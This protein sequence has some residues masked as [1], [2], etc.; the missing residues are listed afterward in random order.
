ML[1]EIISLCFA[2]YFFNGCSKIK[3]SSSLINENKSEPSYRDHNYSY[4]GQNLFYKTW[5]G[6]KDCK[7]YTEKYEGIYYQ[8]AGDRCYV[9]LMVMVVEHV[10]I[11]VKKEHVKIMNS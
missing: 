10:V 11:I 5:E 3:T 1:T 7:K 2:S 9:M 6:D 4:V 8:K